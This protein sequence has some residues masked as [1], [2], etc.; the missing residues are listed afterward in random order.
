MQTLFKKL[1]FMLL[2]ATCVHE[3][4][5]AQTCFS[6]NTINNCVAHVGL[7]VGTG[8][9][10]TVG[11]AQRN[12]TAIIAVTA[13]LVAAIIGIVKCINSFNAPDS[14]YNLLLEGHLKE[15]QDSLDLMSDT[16]MKILVNRT[17]AFTYACAKNSTEIIKKL[18]PSFK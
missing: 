8:L 2:F 17:D 15:F 1:L 7:F 5:S 4:Q 9:K 3:A 10:N 6:K 16:S 14:V 18:L 13:C 11:V 12:S